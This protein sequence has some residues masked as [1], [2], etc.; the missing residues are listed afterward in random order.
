MRAELLCPF[1]YFGASDTVGYRSTPWRNSK[2][3]LNT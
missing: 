2:F 1:R 3:D